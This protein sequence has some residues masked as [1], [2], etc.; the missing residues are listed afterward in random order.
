V[1]GQLDD[2]RYARADAVVRLA[3]VVAGVGPLGVVDDERAVLEDSHVQ[4]RDDRLELAGRL[5]I[6]VWWVVVFGGDRVD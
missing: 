4:R 5:A 1:H 2:L 3:Q 6:Q